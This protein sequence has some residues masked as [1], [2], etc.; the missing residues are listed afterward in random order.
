MNTKNKFLSFKVLTPAFYIYRNYW[1]IL[2]VLFIISGSY[3]VSYI[4]NNSKIGLPNN[5]LYPGSSENLEFS[6]GTRQ[7]DQK[8]ILA[9]DNEDILSGFNDHKN[10]QLL[11]YSCA[12]DVADLP[13][14]TLNY[15][16]NEFVRDFQI[17]LTNPRSPPLLS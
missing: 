6:N 15:S 2:L 8:F 16:E 1:A 17:S 11:E 3:T 5:N 9:D 4:S 14:E 7:D 13:L 12:K 10:N